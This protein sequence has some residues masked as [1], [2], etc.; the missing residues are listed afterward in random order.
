MTRRRVLTD[1]D[2][3]KARDMRL[4]GV[5]CWRIAMALRVS[6]TTIE[7]RLSQPYKPVEKRA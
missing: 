7:R 3:A 5:P 2:L 6:L 1:A 4:Q